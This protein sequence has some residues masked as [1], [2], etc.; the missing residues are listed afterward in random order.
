MK[1][2]TILTTDRIGVLAYILNFFFSWSGPL[3]KIGSPEEWKNR[4]QKSIR[5][6][7]EKSGV[8]IK[9]IKLKDAFRFELDKDF[10][11][12][13]DKILAIFK[14]YEY[15]KV[16]DTKDPELKNTIKRQ[17]LTYYI[18]VW[19]SIYGLVSFRIC[20][21]VPFKFYINPVNFIFPTNPF[22]FFQTHFQLLKIVPILTFYNLLLIQTLRNFS[23]SIL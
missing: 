16:L 2:S 14:G 22:F 19:D 5:E 18:M 7:S 3:A 9:S 1:N 8:E 17:V 11:L 4:I 20:T 6:L 23:F 12:K 10:A 13:E 15:W 21:W